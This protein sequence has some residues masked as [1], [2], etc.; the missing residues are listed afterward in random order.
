MVAMVLI[1][2]SNLAWMIVLAAVV[3][4]Y[5]VAP[6]PTPRWMLTLSAAMV[7]LGVAYAVGT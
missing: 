7:A 3:L 5:K 6:A 4:V 1:G 2:M